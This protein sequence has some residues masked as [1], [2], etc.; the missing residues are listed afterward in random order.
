LTILQKVVP[1]LIK[2]DDV[3]ETQTIIL[4]DKLD[5][6]AIFIISRRFAHLFKWASNN[7]RFVWYA[8]QDAYHSKFVPS[9]FSRKLGSWLKSILNYGGYYGKLRLPDIWCTS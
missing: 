8:Q 5:L 6:L 4:A 7:I 9:K 1:W 3:I 2:H